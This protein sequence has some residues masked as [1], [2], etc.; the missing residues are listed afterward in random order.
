MKVER[1]GRPRGSR[2]GSGLRKWEPTH[3]KFEYEFVLLLHI[4]GK[5]HKEIQEASGYSVAQI[6]N[7]LEGKLAKARIEDVRK[8]LGVDDIIARKIRIEELAHK[9]VEEVLDDEELRQSAEGKFRVADRAIRAIEVI[10]KTAPS[11]SNGNG[12]NITNNTMILAT[13][14]NVKKLLA[15]NDFSNRVKEIH[16]DRSRIPT[17]NI[18]IGDNRSEKAS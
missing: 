11:E 7:I 3:W 6:I 16:G 1:R 18:R 12:V 15:A 10:H 17:T 13:E 5:T 4:S 2:N 8:R 9:R 14:D